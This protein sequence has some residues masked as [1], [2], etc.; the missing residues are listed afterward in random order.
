MLT[1]DFLDFLVLGDRPLGERRAKP[2]CCRG[3]SPYRVENLP[4]SCWSPHGFDAVAKAAEF[5]D[6]FISAPLS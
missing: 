3:A 4:P 6:H 1:Q 2:A 5:T